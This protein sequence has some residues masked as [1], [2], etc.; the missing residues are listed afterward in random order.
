MELRLRCGIITQSRHLLGGASYQAALVC[1]CWQIVA[2]VA[3]G[4][5]LKLQEQRAG[6]YL[7]LARS[8]NA[9]LPCFLAYF[10]DVSQVTS[11]N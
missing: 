3:V 2:M 8:I 10:Q 6:A 5:K 4:D 7:V 11:I 9:L 1:L